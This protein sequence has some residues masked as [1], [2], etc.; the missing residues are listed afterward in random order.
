ERVGAAYMPISSQPI[1]DNNNLS[2]FYRERARLAM[3]SGALREAQRLAEA[4]VRHAR[5][6]VEAGP[7]AVEPV[8]FLSEALVAQGGAAVL[9]GDRARARALGRESLELARQA[10]RRERGSGPARSA[11]VLALMLLG[12]VEQDQRLIREAYNIMRQME[13]DGQ[14]EPEQVQALRMMERAGIR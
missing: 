8:I 3:M 10:Q 4:S 12:D 13:R 1:A 7:R 9:S 6:A 14:L 2:F 11:E 5:A